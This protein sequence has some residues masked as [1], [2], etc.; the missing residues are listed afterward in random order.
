[1]EVPAGIDVHRAHS[2]ADE[3]ERRIAAKMN[4]DAVVHV[5]PQPPPEEEG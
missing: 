4:A 3:V 1:M 5:D 2:I